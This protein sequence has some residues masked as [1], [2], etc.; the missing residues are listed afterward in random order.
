[1]RTTSPT[2]DT[3]KTVWYWSKK[4]L[5]V[6]IFSL[7]VNHLAASDNFLENEAYR[8]PT[9]GVVFTIVLSILVII[10]ADINFNYYKKKYFSKKIEIS[11]IMR[12]MATTL[13]YITLLYVPLNI[14]VE[15]AIGG[16]VQFYL[17]LIGLIITLLICFILI[18]LLYA[19]DLHALYKL[20]IKGAEITIESGAKTTKLPYEHIA[21]FYSEHKIVYTV[22]YDG[23]TISTDFT[24]NELEEKIND[25]LFFR[26]NRQLII[27]KDAVAQV[28]KIENG[29]LRIRLKAA[30]QN[31]T[32]AQI[33]ISRYKRKTF[34]DWFE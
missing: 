27:H 11:A 33:T 2:K 9:I 7:V 22:Q 25:Q 5:V 29:K 12:F 30:I 26:A 32:M 16:H 1:M 14:I 15:L 19:Q 34:L 24:L 21:Y 23:T 6:V 28:E 3:Q 17:I 8:F 31:E 18:A 4:A 20:S 13:G 10:I